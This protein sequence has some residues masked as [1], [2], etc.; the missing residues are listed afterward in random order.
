MEK[1]NQWLKLLISLLIV[2]AAAA[3]LGLFGSDLLYRAAGQL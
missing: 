3:L 1:R 2:G